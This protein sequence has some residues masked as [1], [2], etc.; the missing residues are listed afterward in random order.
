MKKSLC[1]CLVTLCILHGT[2]VFGQDIH[3]SQLFETPL[4]RNPAL[5]GIFSGDIR[6]QSVYR[7]QWNSLTDA[8]H[9]AAANVEYKIP[10]GQTNDYLTLGGQVLYDRAGTVALT[11]TH[12]L[13]AFNYHKSL[14]A[15]RNMYVSMALMGGWVQRSV[16]RSKITTN[17]QY[18][19]SSYDGT[20]ATGETFPKA[21]YSYFDGSAG[22]SF[23][24]QLGENED[25]NL[26]IG[27]AYHHFN[28]AK[29]IVFY[30]SSQIEN[31]PKWVGSAAIRMN[32]T[33]YAYFTIEGDYSTQGT[34]TEILAGVLYSMKLDDAASPKY[35]FHAGTYLRL[36]DAII[37]VVKVEAKPLAVAVSY[38][39]N[40]S[41]LKKV[42]A[43]RGGFEISLTY[44]GFLDKYNSSKNATR[45]PKF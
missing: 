41:T 21:N 28:R 36:K 30:S 26:I 44:Q 4:L 24:S 18:N 25:N 29:N 34:Y 22:L 37:P 6:V 16:D 13:P 31:I 8:Y 12:I 17:S 3:F 11:S 42:S 39:V 23:N 45:C 5:A 15:E 40:I 33:P 1:F 7:S 38:D 19:G 10:V 43:G 27:I 14:S 20:A 9:T 2:G 32:M 35:L